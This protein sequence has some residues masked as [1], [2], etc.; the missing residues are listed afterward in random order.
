MR[1]AVQQ[2]PCKRLP[3][4][5]RL[6]MH[7]RGS[8]SQLHHGVRQHNLQFPRC[9]VHSLRWGTGYSNVASTGCHNLAEAANALVLNLEGVS[10]ESRCAQ[11]VTSSPAVNVML[12]YGSGTLGL[13]SVDQSCLPAPHSAPQMA[14]TDAAS[15]NTSALCSGSNR[16]YSLCMITPRPSQRYPP[17][18][19]PSTSPRNLQTRVFSLSRCLGLHLPGLV[20]RRQFSA[21]HGF[22]LHQAHRSGVVLLL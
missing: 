10:G 12:E 3:I 16:L 14:C 8:P 17:E 6:A 21:C 22:A 1:A 20:H 18:Q 2:Q 11:V 5:S 19:T 9:S 4:P 7:P 13:S 15:V